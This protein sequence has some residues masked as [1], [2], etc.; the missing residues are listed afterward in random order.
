MIVKAKEIVVYKRKERSA[1]AII[2]E[3]RTITKT[4]ALKRLKAQ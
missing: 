3:L 2:K 4:R 1:K